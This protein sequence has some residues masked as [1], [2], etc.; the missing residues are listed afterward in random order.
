MCDCH[1]KDSYL[2]LLSL[3]HRWAL[4]IMMGTFRHR[5]DHG[6]SQTLNPAITGNFSHMTNVIIIGGGV[7]GLTTGITLLHASRGIKFPMTV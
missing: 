5:H 7:I 3:P 6:V 4:E 1:Q 2:N